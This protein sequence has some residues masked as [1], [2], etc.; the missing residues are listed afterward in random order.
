[1]QWYSDSLIPFY[2][3]VPVQNSY[4]DLFDLVAFFKA[5]PALAQAIGENGRRFALED[6]SWEGMQAYHTLALL[7]YARALADD[8]EAMTFQ[9]S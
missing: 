4:A 6:W 7:E 5:R 9:T 3:Y 2:H 8:R 1:M